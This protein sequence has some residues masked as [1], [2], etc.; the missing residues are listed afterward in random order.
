MGR[1]KG[2]ENKK[3]ERTKRT[4]KKSIFLEKFRENGTVYHAAKAAGIGRTAVYQWRDEDPE[5]A[6][7]WEGC[8]RDCVE[9]MEQSLYKRGLA[10]DNTASIFWLKGA[11]P[12]K[13]K[14]RVHQERHE[15]REEKLTLEIDFKSLDRREITTFRGVLDKIA[16]RNQSSED[17]A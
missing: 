9:V 15:K 11:D 4:I 12:D 5:F 17:S 3:P 13:Y 14:E 10:G 16:R 1:P 2:S 7:A 8:Y 6:K